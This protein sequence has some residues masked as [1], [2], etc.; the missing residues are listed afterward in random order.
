[1]ALQTF[2]KKTTGWCGLWYHEETRA[3]SSARMNL[4]VLKSFKG[5]VQIYMK[6][7]KFYQKNTNRPN[8]VFTICDSNSPR[9][10]QDVEVID[11]DWDYEEW[12]KLYNR[13]GI[14]V[15]E[16]GDRFYSKKEVEQML[17]EIR[18]DIQNG[19]RPEDFY[20]EDYMR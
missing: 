15:D 17:D 18:F 6:K 1:M 19:K 13:N 16:D 14:F 4:S 9:F 3:Y 11:D 7:N 20:I 2:D 12:L 8:F 10:A 5:N